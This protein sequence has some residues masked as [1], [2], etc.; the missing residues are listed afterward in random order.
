MH[1]AEGWIRFQCGQLW[2]TEPRSSGG[3]GK[4][5]HSRVTHRGG[6][7]LLGTAQHGRHTQAGENDIVQHLSFWKINTYRSVDYQMFL[8]C[9]FASF[10]ES[11]SEL[12]KEKFG[13][14]RRGH[15]ESAAVV[16]SLWQI[17]ASGNIFVTASVRIW[18]GFICLLVTPHRPPIPYSPLLPSS[19]SFLPLPAFLPSRGWQTLV[20]SR[21]SDP[22]G[23]GFP[24]ARGL[25]CMSVFMA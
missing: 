25:C 21:Y 20:I 2:G 9:S 22:G 12:E 10:V 1:R 24:L 11:Q 14:I 5:S 3:R 23:S 7:E 16:L 17:E 15:L 18:G 19:S 6:W 13:V 8:C 4:G